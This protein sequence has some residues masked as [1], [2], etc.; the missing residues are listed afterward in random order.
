MLTQ[1]VDRRVVR[2]RMAMAIGKCIRLER[3]R[4]NCSSAS[5]ACDVGIT[6]GAL[7]KI[8]GGRTLPSLNTLKGISE[9]LGVRISRLLQFDPAL[10]EAGPARPPE[11]C[12][13]GP[14]RTRSM[15][16]NWSKSRER[17]RVNR[18]GRGDRKR[19]S[20]KKGE[21]R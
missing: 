8:E 9:S 11:T 3:S 15:F 4:Q 14:A 18:P 20:V 6:P 10:L 17:S 2:Q 16:S 1:V 5:L 21:T 13:K 19:Q 7:S 12:R